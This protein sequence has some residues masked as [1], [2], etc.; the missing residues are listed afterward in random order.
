M[1]NKIVSADL[2]EKCISLNHNINNKSN[3]PLAQRKNPNILT[4]KP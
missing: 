2:S 3:Y 1:K 4:L